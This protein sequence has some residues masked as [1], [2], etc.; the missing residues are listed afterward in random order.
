MSGREKR[1]S[2]RTKLRASVK[3]MHPRLGELMLHTGDIS[4]GGAYILHHG[5][6]MPDIGDIVDVQVQGI[7]D[8]EAPVVKMEVI[9][10]D[11]QG[12]GLAFIDL[13]SDDN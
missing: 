6:N 2:V 11:K 1:K 12:L 9:R 13:S 3:V 5:Q 4:D 8:G 7:G 10:T